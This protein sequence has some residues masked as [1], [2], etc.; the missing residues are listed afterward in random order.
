[1]ALTEK[2]KNIVGYKGKSLVLSSAGC[3]YKDTLISVNRCGA[4]RKYT[5]EYIYNQFKNQKVCKRKWDLSF[6]TQIRSLIYG[7]GLIQLNNLIDIWESGE[8]DIFELTLENGYKIK[9][10]NCHRYMTKDGWK[11][12]KDLNNNDYV[13]I[14]TIKR[15]KKKKV[16]NK[17]PKKYYKETRVGKYYKNKRDCSEG[18]TTK[19][20]RGYDH[21]MVYE[22]FKNNIPYNKFIEYTYDEKLSKNIKYYINK[23]KYHIHHKNKD[24]LDNS[25]DNLELLDIKDHLRQHSLDAYSNF[26]HGT[27]DYSKVVSIVDLGVKEMTYDIECELPNDNFVANSIVVHNSGK[28]YTVIERIKKLITIDKIPAKEVAL[29][30]FSRTATKEIRDRLKKALSYEDYSNLYIATIHSFAYKILRENSSYADFQIIDSNELLNIV[31]KFID[32]DVEYRDAKEKDK[33]N[34][35]SEIVNLISKACKDN[36]K[37]IVDIFEGYEDKVRYN[38]IRDWLNSKK[39]MTFDDILWL[40]Y[41]YIVKYPKIK[42]NYKKKY[43]IT[44]ECQDTSRIQIDILQMFDFGDTDIQLIGDIQQTIYGFAGSDPYYLLE[45]TATYDILQMDETFRFGETISKIANKVTNYFSLEDKYKIETVTNQ[46]SLDVSHIRNDND[47]IDLVCNEISSLISSGMNE[48]DISV[49]CRTN[50]ELVNYSKK[51][52]SMRIKNVMRFGTLWKRSEVKLLLSV[53]SLLRE[54]RLDNV[55]FFLKQ[56]RILIED[57]VFNHIY[58]A[59]VTE[60]DSVDVDIISLLDFAA[61][62]KVDKVGA[63]RLESIV[64]LRDMFIDAKS[65]IDT[66]TDFTVFSKIAEVIDVDSMQFMT[67]GANKDGVD[68]RDERW[69]FIRLLDSLQR[70]HNISAYELETS[71]KIDFTTE[72]EKDVNAVYLRT[73]HSSKGMTIPY[74]FVDLSNFFKRAGDK[75]D[76][77]SELFLLYVAIT[78][79]KTKLY[80]CDANN[81]DSIY[82]FVFTE[83]N[84]S[85]LLNLMKDDSI[86]N[87]DFNRKLNDN[88]DSILIKNVDVYKNN[89]SNKSKYFDTEIEILCVERDTVKA[90]FM[91]LECKFGIKKFWVAKQ[92]LGCKEVDSIDKFYMPSWV[93]EKN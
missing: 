74:C 60:K 42:Q 57:R 61:H 81:Q 6:T 73:V 72:E 37:D 40:C 34:K 27:P 71:L 64:E 12:L 1:M 29:F 52:T 20:Y 55:L 11:Q 17:Q 51:L 24:H 25:I 76:V 28:T 4:G 63:K 87:E 44:D 15:H 46:K 66:N 54:F 5:I 16:Y 86:S 59:Y 38:K 22:A 10:T 93:L 43:V 77:E 33:L 32:S 26:G 2:Q 30:S 36:L 49:L 69:S 89:Y 82:N 50:A 47:L 84:D 53:V 65:V 39:L 31:K 67:G 75:K 7:E 45:K 83:D 78:R 79:A 85:E 88:S 13:M 23:K 9:S 56:K 3:L 70:E 92:L 21:I 90:L 35:A 41:Q 91:E 80:L 19:Y 68:N 18:R 14:D 58:N 8:K 62:N 48:K